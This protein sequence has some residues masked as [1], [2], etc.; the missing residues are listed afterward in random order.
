MEESDEGKVVQF[1]FKCNSS[2][3]HEI[4]SDR[5]E[6]CFVLFIIETITVGCL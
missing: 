4:P 3:N 2:E 6:V 5:E 1:R